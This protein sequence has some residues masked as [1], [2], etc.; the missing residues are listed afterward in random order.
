VQSGKSGG[1]I[2]IASA[3]FVCPALKTRAPDDSVTLAVGC[4]VRRHGTPAVAYTF[5][6]YK[7]WPDI[8]MPKDIRDIVEENYGP[9]EHPAGPES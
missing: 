3:C 2:T 4:L 1:A 6:H 9:F 5:A 8:D 7:G